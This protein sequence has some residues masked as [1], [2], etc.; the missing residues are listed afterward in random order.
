VRPQDGGQFC[1]IP[2]LDRNHA[3]HGWF[4][5]RRTRGGWM[6]I[7]TRHRQGYEYKHPDNS[8]SMSPG[9]PW[10]STEHGLIPP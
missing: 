10:P 8:A 6:G 9:Q 7:D 5:V 1:R 4:H 2:V 3:R